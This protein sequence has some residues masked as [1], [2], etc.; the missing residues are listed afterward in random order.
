VSNTVKYYS[1][2]SVHLHLTDFNQ[3][4]VLPDTTTSL[5]D[6]TNDISLPT[7]AE[8]TETVSTTGQMTNMIMN[9]II[10]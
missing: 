10:Q 2:I 9:I 6:H 1:N 7:T 8:T 3:S 5:I 4:T